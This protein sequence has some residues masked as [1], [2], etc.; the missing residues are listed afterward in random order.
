[1]VLLPF[2]TVEFHPCTVMLPGLVVEIFVG[3]LFY[4]VAQL[5]FH[6]L[7][8]FRFQF[9]KAFAVYSNLTWVLWENRG[10]G[11]YRKNIDRGV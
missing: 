8:C 7:N 2:D 4:F 10:M 5:N 11:K 1:M 3:I 6:P 9:F